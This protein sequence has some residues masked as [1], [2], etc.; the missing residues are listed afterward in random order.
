MQELTIT[1]T[2][3]G[4]S[5]ETEEDLSEARTE[6]I[7]E[8]ISVLPEGVTNALLV[9]EGPE[10]SA[11]YVNSTEGLCAVTARAGWD[12]FLELIGADQSGKVIPYVTGG[13]SMKIAARQLV[14]AETAVVV[15]R[16]FL[17]TGRVDR[18]SNTWEEQFPRAQ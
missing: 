4:R 13:Q 1:L 10:T 9:I 3:Y 16:E 8:A 18:E 6:E 17:L 2:R 15:I 14:S 5:G 12:N 7:L 11:L